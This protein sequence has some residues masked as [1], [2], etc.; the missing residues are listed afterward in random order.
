MSDLTPA[1]RLNLSLEMFDLGVEI[2]RQNLRRRHPDE[3]DA[4]IAKR[5]AAWLS[6]RPGAEFGDTVG[7][8][9]PLP[10]SAT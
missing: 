3:D 8:V 9:R 7:R 6:E 5:L 1:E 2:M 10:E 4:A